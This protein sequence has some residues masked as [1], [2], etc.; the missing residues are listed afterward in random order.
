MAV[1]LNARG[2]TVPYFKIGKRGTTIYQGNTDPVA[3]SYY[4]NNGDIWID[5]NINKVK[6]RSPSGWYI[7]QDSINDLIDVDI[8]SNAPTDGQTLVWDN[9]NSKFIPADFSDLT[10]VAS[11][12]VPTTTNTYDIGS[13]TKVWNNIWASTG[14]IDNLTVSGDLIVSGSVT[15]IDTTNL[16]I[17]DN[18]I[19]LN[20]DVTGTPT[21]DAGLEIERGTST[22]VS[23]AWNESTDRWTFT[24][25]G[26]TYY[27]LIVD[28]D[29]I[30]EGSSNEFYDDSKVDARIAN[31]SIDDLADVDLTTTAP[32]NGQI[33]S[34][35]NANSKFVPTNQF[36]TTDLS[37][38]SPASAYGTGGI[39]YNNTTGVFT[40]IPPDLSGYVVTWN[41]LTGTPT[42]IAGYGITDAFDG[43][44]GSLTNTPSIPSSL[45]DLNTITDGM[46]GQVL[47]T[48][49]SA[50]FSFGTLDISDLTDGAGLLYTDSSVRSA[51]SATGNLSYDSNTGV[52]TTTSVFTGDVKG[53][54]LH[55]TTGAT[56]VNASGGIYTLTGNV[57]G[58]LYG[59]VLSPTQNRPIITTGPMTDLLT[60]ADAEIEKIKAP[61]V[62]G[63]AGAT[64][65]NTTGADT[66]S[67]HNAH[68]SGALYGD[69]GDTVANNPVLTVGTGNN[70][71]QLSVTTASIDDLNV[72]N[73]T[74]FRTITHQAIS[75]DHYTKQYVLSGTTTD[76]TETELF[77]RGAPNERI[78]VATDTTIFYDISFVARR[79]DATG[80]SAG[81]ELKG[82]VDN[83]AGTVADVG[84]LYEI[85]VASDNT[86]LL[87]EA[88]ADDTN[89]SI[90]ISV[91]GEASKTFRWTAVVKT[92]E[93]AQ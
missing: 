46:S 10:S 73:P 23:I 88:S 43:D 49:G 50:A 79:T 90:K 83:F 38:G 65:I 35:D 84:D 64:I 32:T 81:F 62:G 86:N 24:N 63:V 28:S 67:G 7:Q 5:N 57:A 70:D 42:T 33:L 66:F 40:Y 91:T 9:S 72:K 69:V 29:D 47:Q 39:T 41:D 76:A 82:V 8:S 17:S 25:D 56:V 27:N 14:N 54:I 78:P 12:I 71:S 92:T 26:T 36:S 52:M 68:L 13:S 30:A 55:P 11:N 3:E 37:V 58:D 4:V 75:S 16:T 31:A 21:E 77:V 1:T 19:V 80:E 48:N 51:I 59:D 61:T 18:I 6:F 22:N 60:I 74:I 85:L 34:W 93:V 89:D 15:T 20:N 45:L 53:N 87:V 44:Y 2:T